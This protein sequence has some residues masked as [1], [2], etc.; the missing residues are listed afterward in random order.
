MVRTDS[1]GKGKE[2]KMQMERAEDFSWDIDGEGTLT[3]TGTGRMP[4]L[5]GRNH[6]QSLWE[7]IKETIRKVEIGE[8]ITEIGLRN[9]E[10]CTN[11]TEV[12]LPATLTRIR[13]YAF[14]GCAALETVKAETAEAKTVKAETE[15]E[16][17]E[18]AGARSRQFRYIYDKPLREEEGIAGKPNIGGRQQEKEEPA[19]IFG[20]GAFRGTS[21]AVKHFGEFY[22]RDGIL[23]IC[24]SEKDVI[25]VPEG[26]RTISMFS[27]REVCA[28]ELILPGSLTKIEDYAFGGAR[29]D[30]IVMPDGMNSLLIREY[31]GS[32]L[33][34]IRSKKPAERRTKFFR[35]PLLYELALQKTNYKGYR[36][37]AVREKKEAAGKKRWGRKLVDVGGSLKRR[38]K[39]GGVL[40]GIR[41][42][43][44]HRVQSVKSF[45]WL[46]DDVKYTEPVI[47]E[48]LMYP[49]RLEDGSIEPYSDSTTFQE[50]KQL[51]HGFS[52]MNAEE[53]MKEGAIRFPQPGTAEEWF[54][55]EDRLNFEGAV[56]IELLEM[57]M[58]DHPGYSIDTMEENREKERY[59]M[60]V[61]V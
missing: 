27:F 42:N 30:K 12:H 33:E 2:I 15:T 8:G 52:D 46:E 45:V 60:F 19:V 49:V 61:D 4:D 34:A 25:E 58:K 32:I 51:L 9:F 5:G 16:N 31:G 57:W 1:V 28:K 21:W 36:K 54:W 50:P 6:S 17:A 40:V 53:L 43:G 44:Q 20:E 29:I 48:Y 13:A 7:D 3:V 38:L 24:F 23:Y 37:F 35:V 26:V 47:D 22:C 55:S 11:L 41:W 39:K 10:G 14:R 18:T 59:R 56:E